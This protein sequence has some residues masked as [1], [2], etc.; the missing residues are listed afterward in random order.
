MPGTGS[1][2]WWRTKIAEPGR[3][4]EL[5]LDPRVAA[6]ADLAVVEVGLGRV[7][8][9]HGDAVVAEHRVPVAEELLEVDVA[10]VARVVVA[11]DDD[12]RVAVEPVEVALGLDVLLLEARGRQV[13]RADDD[14]G[15]GGVDVGDRPFHQVGH[16]VR[17]AAVDVR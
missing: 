11:R 16:E 8:R 6:A 9:D 12:K 14:V 2:W 5:L 10:D 7:D 1:R 15:G 4:R 17:V 3:G 13:T